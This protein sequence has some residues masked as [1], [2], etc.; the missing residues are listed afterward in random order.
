MWWP[1][2]L[3]LLYTSLHVPEY[4][5]TFGSQVFIQPNGCDESS[6]RGGFAP[7]DSLPKDEN[8]SY[9]GTP[10]KNYC[11][12]DLTAALNAVVSHTTVHLETANYSIDRF[13]LIQN[14]INITL[15]AELEGV[16]I[17]CT[18]NA[19]LAFVNVSQL[20]VF[21]IVIDRCGFTG[22]D[23]ENTLDIMKNIV[24][25]FY[26]IPK[27]VKIAM[28]FGHCENVTLEN[29]TVMNTRGFGLVGINVI[30]SSQLNSV[31]F[32]NNT[33]P[34]TCVSPHFLGIFPSKSIDFDS[35][36]RLGGAAAF[37]YFDYH[38]QTLHRGNWFTLRIQNCNFTFNAECSIV[39]LNLLRIPG[40]G[41]SSF[42]ANT[43]YRLGGSGA[44]SL[45]LAQ[46]QYRIDIVVKEST[47]NTNNGSSGGGVLISLF[48][49]VRNTHVTFDDCQFEKS[50]VAFFNDIRLPQN[51][52]HAVNLLNRDT[53]I[54]LL[55]SNFTNNVAQG[56]NST[57]ILF[58]NYYSA[59]NSISEVVRIYIDNCS[60]KENRAFVGSAIII[61]ERKFNG[62][63]VGM[64]V[65]IKDTDFINNEIL[66]ADQDAIVTI[67][68]S[69]GTVD[70]RNV[71]LTFI[72][73]CSFINNV[74]TALRTESSMIG[75]HGNIT[76]LRNIGIYGGALYLVEFSYLIMNR[77]S[78]IYFLENEARI[79]GGAVFVNE[80]GLNSHLIGGF[81]DCFIHFA[82]DNFVLCEN[83]SDLESFNVYI[84][85]S[86]NR[87]P[88]TGRM[89]SGSA[90][91]TC[92]WAFGV[93]NQSTN[94]DKS[95]FEILS[96]EYSSTFSFDEVPDNPTLVRSASARLEIKH[97]DS[98]Q[99]KI[100]QVFPGQ[101]FHVNISAIDDFENTVSNVVAAFA[102]TDTPINLI[103][104][105]TD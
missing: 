104:Q 7:D 32:F 16:S 70:I 94:P 6:G 54:S 57:L 11:T 25:V 28:L 80:N 29:V 99:S 52:A 89:V 85:F 10:Y 41:E 61:Y 56:L 96:K 44:L 72:G 81:V 88:G 65:S 27:V 66:N 51:I 22:I 105:N 8:A 30:G 5:G 95:L 46:L 24:N 38:D 74:G 77:N 83:C 2:A 35:R 17:Q 19:G 53:S 40:R 45:A 60:F 37:M 31:L 91:S 103:E 9:Y 92:P 21:N 33:H 18:K 84:Q 68:Q 79:E 82:Y 36:N 63:D 67:S 87:A 62:L 102:S 75:V 76:F 39:Y 101:V 15:E 50:A 14:V 71:N 26:I 13:I 58:S 69:A 59:V 23:I 64:Q 78:S 55:N 47:F 43:G 20:S 100:T 97:L 86:G 48:T 1:I 3:L 49:G 4:S 34:G 90:L 42:I 12:E 73:N 98:Y 93:L